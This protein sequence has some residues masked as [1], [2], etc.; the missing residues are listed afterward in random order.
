MSAWT[1]IKSL[2]SSLAARVTLV[3][4]N[5]PDQGQVTPGGPVRPLRLM[6]M[7]VVPGPLIK[8]GTRRRFRNSPLPLNLR[9]KAAGWY[10]SL[11]FHYFLSR[12]VFIMF[13]NTLTRDIGLKVGPTMFQVLVEHYFD[14][15]KLD[16]EKS[17]CL[18]QDDVLYHEA[19]TIVKVSYLFL[20]PGQSLFDLFK[21]LFK[22]FNIVSNSFYTLLSIN[23]PSM[24]PYD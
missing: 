21:G 16:V 11:L 7:L 18:K 17:D 10:S 3:T 20:G 22:C 6:T 5:S 14:R 12:P 23:N 15:L 13:A 9:S 2:K 24:Q 4:I 19:F 8:K 1:Y